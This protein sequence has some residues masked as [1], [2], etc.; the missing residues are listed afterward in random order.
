MYTSL[1]T[2][3][4]PLSNRGGMYMRLVWELK[5]E[6]GDGKGHETQASPDSEQKFS[7]ISF[8]IDHSMAC[9]LCLVRNLKKTLNKQ[10]KSE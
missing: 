10:M 4:M 2:E 7:N 9:R 5:H 3:I 1:T 8:L 6:P